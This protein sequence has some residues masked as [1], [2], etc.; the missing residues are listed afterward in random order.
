MINFSRRVWAPSSQLCWGLQGYAAPG[1]P[2]PYMQQPYP[3]Q[4]GM[5]QQPGYPPQAW[6]SAPMQGSQPPGYA[7]QADSS[8]LQQPQPA[9][10]EPCVEDGHRARPCAMCL[11]AT[12][13]LS[14]AAVSRGCCAGL[15][16]DPHAKLQPKLHFA[17]HACLTTAARVVDTAQRIAWTSCLFALPPHSY[18]L[19]CCR[20]SRGHSTQLPGRPDSQAGGAPPQDRAPVLPA[21]PPGHRGCLL[22]AQPRAFALHPVTPGQVCGRPAGA[23]PCNGAGV[24]LWTVS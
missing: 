14:P 21:Q 19:T 12:L 5:P 24:W 3:G 2:Y 6:G 16:H 8:H 23:T 22:P 17:G 7:M 1:Q 4:P 15:K 10:G 11:G 20:P 9:A 13:L 18:T